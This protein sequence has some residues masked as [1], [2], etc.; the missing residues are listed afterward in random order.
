MCSST[1]SQEDRGDP[2]MGRHDPP[3]LVSKLRP[4]SVLPSDEGSG[5]P[6]DKSWPQTVVPHQHART[7]V[8]APVTR[9]SRDIIGMLITYAHSNQL[10]GA[11]GPGRFVNTD[12]RCANHLINPW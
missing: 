8:S 1:H 2:M 12:Y 11:R 7:W 10:H 5:V 9:G 3:P 6:T 4:A